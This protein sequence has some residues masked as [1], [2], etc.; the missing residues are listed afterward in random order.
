MTKVK[1]KKWRRKK[2]GSYGWILVSSI[3]K[4]VVE[5]G[6]ASSRKG[7]GGGSKAKQG[8]LFWEEQAGAQQLL[9]RN[10]AVEIKEGKVKTA[11]QPGTHLP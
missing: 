7:E 6:K 4:E 9:D 11:Q 2:D 1:T 8:I 3:P 10:T 5:G